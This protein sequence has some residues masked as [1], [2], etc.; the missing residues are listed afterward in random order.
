MSIYLTSQ[1]KW[2]NFLKSIFTKTDPRRNR[3]FEVSKIGLKI[4]FV[5]ET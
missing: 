5:V 2:M 1:V 3:K 4:E